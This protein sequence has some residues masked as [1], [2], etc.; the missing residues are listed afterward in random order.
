L[1]N[2]EPQVPDGRR[3][4]IRLDVGR[5]VRTERKARKWSQADLAAQ[6]G[7]HPE[8]IGR[9]ERGEVESSVLLRV[10]QSFGWS[11]QRVSEVIEGRDLTPLHA[12]DYA[13]LARGLVA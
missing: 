1:A 3:G 11:P 10:A 12:S 4:L 8:T 6:I 13:A 7:C 5:R 9:L 2:G